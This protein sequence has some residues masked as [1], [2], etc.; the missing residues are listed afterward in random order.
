MGW[1]VWTVLVPLALLSAGYGAFRYMLATDA[2]GLLDAGDRLFRGESAIRQVAK[3][4]YGPDKAQKLEMIVPANGKGPWPVVVFIH[5]GGWDSGDPCSYRFVARALAPRG[6]AVVLAGY[7]L[8]PHARY[9]DMLEDGAAALRWVAD[10]A[11]QYGG[12]PSRVV[13]MGHSAGA[14]NAV[15]L[16]LDRQWLGRQG[17]S[18]DALRG[19]VG[20]SGPYDFYPFDKPSAIHS[21]GEARDPLSTQPV[22]HA[23]AAA[24]PLL[25]VSGDEDTTV[26]PRNA[27]ALAKAMTAAGE[28]T[29]AVILKGV[30]HTGMV[31]KLAQPFARD[32]RVLDTVLP[33]LARV[34][35]RVAAP[36]SAPVQPRAR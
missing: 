14:Y 21:F 35:A 33:F 19:V 31:M 24:P 32:P 8:Y 9:P 27:L 34:T 26:R 36:V 30:D 18:A 16:G 11:G 12:D 3:A 15:M 10:H 4:H 29:T 1:V 17:L 20:L 7:R 25:L 2:V 6:Y 5:G 13:L 23:R 28:P 22:N